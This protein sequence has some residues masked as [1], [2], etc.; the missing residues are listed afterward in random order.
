MTLLDI[1][2]QLFSHFCEEDTF[3][4]QQFSSIEIDK[5]LESSRDDIIRAALDEMVAMGVSKKVGNSLW[6]LSAP[7]NSH[8]QTIQITMPTSEVVAETIETFLK[9]N[10]IDHDP[11]DKFNLHE[12]H[13]WQL[14]G[15]IND[16]VEGP[17]KQGEEEKEE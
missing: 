16:L 4:I 11:V 1:R 7:V 9:A 2:N 14:I 17:E 8:G 10:E 6:M 5:S 3:S 13:I 12:G 15:I